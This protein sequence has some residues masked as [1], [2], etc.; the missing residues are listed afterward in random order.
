MDESYRINRDCDIKRKYIPPSLE[1]KRQ[2]ST[3]TISSELDKTTGCTYIIPHHRK[4]ISYDVPRQLKTITEN[5]RCLYRQ[6]I[7]QRKYDFALDLILLNTHSYAY[8]PC[9]KNYRL[10]FDASNN[11]LE[12]EGCLTPI[13]LSLEKNKWVDNH[14]NEKK[15]SN[16]GR[17]L[18]TTSQVCYNKE[19]AIK[20]IKYVYD[21]SFLFDYTLHLRNQETIITNNEIKCLIDNSYDDSDEENDNSCDDNSSDDSIASFGTLSKDIQIKYHNLSEKIY[22]LELLS[23]KCWEIAKRKHIFP[24]KCKYGASCTSMKKVHLLDYYHL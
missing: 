12:E 15:L 10:I 14:N 20:C 16:K 11:E 23:I 7:D 2:Q 1:R 17:E 4:N 8:I 24:K 22:E 13:K 21:K 6:N 3:K 5:G 18:F 19:Y 9:N